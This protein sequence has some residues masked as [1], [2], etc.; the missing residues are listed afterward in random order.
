MPNGR[1]SSWRSEFVAAISIGL[2]AHARRARGSEAALKQVPVCRADENRLSLFRV[3]NRLAKREQVAVRCKNQQLA[4][5]IRLIY[6]AV[7]VAFSQFVEL[8]FQFSI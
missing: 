7:N 3:L 8:W 2:A 5:A 4:L 6:R 1:K